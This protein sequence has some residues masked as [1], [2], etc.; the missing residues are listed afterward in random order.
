VCTHYSLSGELFPIYFATVIMVNM[1]VEE[2][3]VELK[4]IQDRFAQLVQLINDYDGEENQSRGIRVKLTQAERRL[5][6]I[7]LENA[8]VVDSK[9]EVSRRLAIL[10]ERFNVMEEAVGSVNLDLSLRQ[11]TEQLAPVSRKHVPVAQW[12]LRFDG[13]SQVMSLG[14]FLE[15]VEELRVARNA[16]KSDLWVE[17]V[18]LFTGQALIWFRS[19]RRRVNSWEELVN[20]LKMEFQSADY[21][22]DLW[23]EIRARSQ[24][25][26]ERPGVYFAVMDNLFSRMSAKV[27]T[28]EKLSI[29]KRNL[30]PYFQDRLSLHQVDSVN[31]LRELCKQLDEGKQ[32]MDRFKPPPSLKHLVEPDLG[33]MG[34]RK[35]KPVAA[36]VLNAQ[37]V[38]S[39]YRRPLGCWKCQQE[40]HRF[41]ECTSN[42]DPL[43]C[44]GCGKR[45]IS[46]TACQSCIQQLSE[47]SKRRRN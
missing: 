38:Q 2:A 20:E 35:S 42:L 30:Q 44:H 9:T 32:S 34:N 29:Y 23:D 36:A 27:T 26:N 12:N 17:A 18:D 7:I 40:G 41:R 22:Q 24:G 13:E 3:L 4:N 6:L 46:S 39:H 14:A 10:N 45:G 37:G 31:R 1:N 11:P 15:R 33:Y 5:A 19:V 25:D 21:D 28:A 8:E 16:T 47:N 43:F